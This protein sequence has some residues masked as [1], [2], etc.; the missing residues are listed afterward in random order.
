[1]SEFQ[2]VGLQHKPLFDEALSRENSKSSSD[3]FG[4]VFLWDIL[5]RRNVAVLGER[6]GIEYLCSKGAFYAYP[7]GRGDLVPAIDALRARAAEQGRPLYLEGVTAPQRAALEAALPGRF[8][9]FEDRDDADYIYSVESFATL[10][11]KKLHGK[12][13]FCNRFETA[14]DW[15]YEALSPAG[16]DDCRS[17][18]QS[19][20]A[21]K[22]GHNRIGD[23]RKKLDELRTRAERYERE[24]DL[25]KSSAINYGEIPNIQKEI[26]Q[27]EKNE[28]NVKN[29]SN[30]ANTAAD[31]PMVPDRVDADSVAEIVSD[32]T[33]IPVGRLMQGENEKLLT[34]ED[35]LGKRVIG[36]KEAI[37]AVSDAVRRSRAG[38]SDPNRPTGSFLFLG[39]TGV[40]KTELAK[41][42]ADF[43]FDDE[44]A[45]VR[46]DMSEYMEKAS[47]SR[48]IGAAPGYVGYEQGGQLTY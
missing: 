10:S 40:G 2:P 43:L 14:H 6:L 4:N 19:W 16:F 36:Q 7:S 15:R 46:I 38:I 28:Q 25:A 20:D 11:G 17:L 32:W 26:A 23:L 41:A 45:M 8:R 37:K 29:G 48:L 31:V 13:N 35:Y 3:S 30:A 27:A 44:K 47:V 34:M 24:G 39:P 18:L 33:G 22:N 42:L 1:M 9:F 21:E 12:R 5:C